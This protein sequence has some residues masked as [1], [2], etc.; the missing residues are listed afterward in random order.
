MVKERL[1]QRN[2]VKES[3]P[4]EGL[5]GTESPVHPPVIAKDGDLG[6]EPIHS[7]QEGTSI[8]IEDNKNTHLSE[9]QNS[10]AE[11]IEKI[12]KHQMSHH[13]D[14]S[15]NNPGRSLSEFLPPNYH[16]KGRINLT[17]SMPS[18][19]L[20]PVLGLCAPNANQIESSEGNT[21]KLNWRQNRHVARQ[22]FPFSLAPCT[23]TSM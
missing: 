5:L 10:N 6:A 3:H 18:N 21:S 4:A 11:R 7:V 20:L 14:V 17:N 1:A 15:V 23:G 16:N 22:E 9:A 12:S 13:F 2:A 19:N 8:D